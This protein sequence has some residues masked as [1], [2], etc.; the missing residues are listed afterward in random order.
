MASPLEEHMSQLGL[1]LIELFQ[2]RQRAEL[3]RRYVE[4]LELEIAME[5]LHESLA[6]VADR[7]RNEAA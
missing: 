2:R 3:E 4:V 1:Q 5:A 6:A 7:L